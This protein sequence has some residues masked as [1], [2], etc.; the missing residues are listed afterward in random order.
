MTLISD[1]IRLI[2]ASIIMI[3]ACSVSRVTTTS[4]FMLVQALRED[5]NCADYDKDYGKNQNEHNKNRLAVNWLISSVFDA[6][7]NI[8][9]LT[10]LSGTRS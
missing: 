3:A 5:A 6:C 9:N 10:I 4:I 2:R 8:T 1:V 7:T